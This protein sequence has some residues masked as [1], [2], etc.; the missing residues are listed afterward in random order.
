M[1]AVWGLAKNSSSLLTSVPSL[2]SQTPSPRSHLSSGSSSLLSPC[3]KPQVGL[4]DPET[5]IFFRTFNSQFLSIPIRLSSS[6]CW[7]GLQPRLGMVG[8]RGFPT[9]RR[10]D[11]SRTSWQ[12]DHVTFKGYPNLFQFPGVRPGL[13]IVNTPPPATPTAFCFKGNSLWDLTGLQASFCALL[14]SQIYTRY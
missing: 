7:Q 11:A 4:A 6:E 5:Q 10:M 14:R 2:P 9:S 1:K 12:V 3:V 8:R 13:S